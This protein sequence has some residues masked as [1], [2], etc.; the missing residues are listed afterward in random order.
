MLHTFGESRSTV[1]CIV[2]EKKCEH[3]ILFSVQ[4][5]NIYKV[6]Y[7]TVLVYQFANHECFHLLLLLFIRFKQNML[8]WMR[9]SSDQ[10]ISSVSKG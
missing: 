2:L 3:F 6:W 7:V 8:W 10:V 1:W 5:A 9:L 4:I